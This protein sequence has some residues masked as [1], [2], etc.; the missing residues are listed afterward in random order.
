MALKK[1]GITENTPSE[2]MFSAA[3]I[4]KNLK[5]DTD[6]AGESKG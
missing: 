4:Y 1:H 2:L 3:T 6:W 5:F